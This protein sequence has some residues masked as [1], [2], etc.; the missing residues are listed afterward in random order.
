MSVRVSVMGSDWDQRRCFQNGFLPG[1]AVDKT[2]QFLAIWASPPHF[3]HALLSTQTKPDTVCVG[4]TQ[5]HGHQE[6]RIVG[7]ILEARYHIH[8]S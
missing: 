5:A 8:H 1:L 6:A 7:A 2:L 3:Y 4:T